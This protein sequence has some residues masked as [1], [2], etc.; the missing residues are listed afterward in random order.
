MTLHIFNP[1]HD[2]SLAQNSPNYTPSRAA[3]QIRNDLAFLPYI[4]A[5]QGD[6]VLVSVLRLKNFG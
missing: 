3:L 1:E 6:A 2:M 5:K 4:W